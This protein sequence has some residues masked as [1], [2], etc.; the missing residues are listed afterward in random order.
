MNSSDDKI[1][2]DDS[3]IIKS[4]HTPLS[5]LDSIR[6]AYLALNNSSFTRTNCASKSS[7]SLTPAS[8]PSSAARAAFIIR[9]VCCAE[10]SPSRKETVRNLLAYSM[11]A[12]ASQHRSLSK[13]L[14]QSDFTRIALTLSSPFHP[15]CGLPQELHPLRLAS[16][17]IGVR[18]PSAAACE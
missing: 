7:A 14:A 4:H 5:S 9:A 17:N 1:T 3:S 15:S 10:K 6:R 8:S 12:S 11:S 2:S 13:R 18:K 16:C